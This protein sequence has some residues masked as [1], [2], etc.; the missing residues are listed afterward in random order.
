MIYLLRHGQTEFN[1]QGRYQGGSDSPLTPLGR[2]QAEAQGRRLA[3][4]VNAP[5]IWT[6][7]LPRAV[8]TAALVARHLPGSETRADDRLRELSMGQWEGLTRSE[9]AARW[10]GFRKGHPAGHWVFHAPDGERLDA[11]RARLDAVLSDAGTERRDV[12][13]VGHGVAGRLMRGLHGGLDL[14]A[15][16]ALHAPQGVVFRLRPGGG[17]DAL[18]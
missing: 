7:P 14:A 13:L 18:G 6:S 8:A 5:L 16:L 2:T 9:I 4:L 15:A 10:P 11:L 3:D 1:L 17:I 12:I